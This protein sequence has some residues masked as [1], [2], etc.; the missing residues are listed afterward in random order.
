M[1]LNTLCDNLN[2]DIQQLILLRAMA[3]EA[4]IDLDA[5]NTEL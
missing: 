5:A 1:A 3:Q 2:G 4:A